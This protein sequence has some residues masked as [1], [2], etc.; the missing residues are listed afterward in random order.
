MAVTL[1]NVFSEKDFKEIDKKSSELAKLEFVPYTKKGYLMAKAVF[2]DGSVLCG[3]LGEN[4]KR[5]EKAYITTTNLEDRDGFIKY[6][7][8]HEHYTQGAIGAMLGVAQ[9]TVSMILTKQRG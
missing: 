2:M 5:L 1:L 6:L 4:H 7:Y 8:E 3:F 9:S